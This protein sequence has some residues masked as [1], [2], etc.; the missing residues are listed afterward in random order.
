V[1]FDWLLHSVEIVKWRIPIDR[2]C[3]LAFGISAYMILFNDFAIKTAF[4]RLFKGICG[5]NFIWRRSF[6]NPMTIG[7][8]EGKFGYSHNTPSTIIMVILS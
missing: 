5:M 8:F 6:K 1:R 3:F 2:E 4:Q 7:A